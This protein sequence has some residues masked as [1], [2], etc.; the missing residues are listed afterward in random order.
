M[1]LLGATVAAVIGLGAFA[2]VAHAQSF[3]KFYVG[4]TGYTGP[5]NGAQTVYDQTKGLGTNCPTVGT[6]SSDNIAPSLTFNSA[7][8]ITATGANVWGDFAP[9]FGGLGVGGVGT[10]ADAADDQ[11]EGSEVLRLHFGSAVQLLGVGTL[12]DAGH[13]PFGTNFATGSLVGATNTFLL[14]T[15]GTTFNPVTFGNANNTD[16]GAFNLTFTGQDFYFMQA[17]NQPEFYVSA[18]SFSPLS[19]TAVPGPIAGAGLPA[20]IGLAGAWFWRRR[21]AHAAA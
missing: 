18:V 6:C 5:F 10:S 15:D 8:G 13:T 3:A 16:G 21:R 11:I 19:A 20:L 2:G 1:K 4:G 14:S 9:N 12:F 7:V 17:A